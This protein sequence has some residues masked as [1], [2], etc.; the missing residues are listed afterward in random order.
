MK[1]PV[2]S[3]L[4]VAAFACVLTCIVTWPQVRHPAMVADHF[5]PY[6]SVW[7]LSHIA[8]A[9]TRWPIHLFDGNIFYPL[10]N[11]LA[12]SDATLLQGL[13]AAPFLWAHLSP[14]LVYNLLLLAGFVGSGVGMFVLARH[15][16]GDTGPSLIATTIFTILPYRVEHVMHLELQW[17]MFI[18]LSL[19]AVHRTMESGR[20]RYGLLAGLFVWLQFLSCVYYGVFLGLA[21]LVFVPLLLTFKGHAPP[22]A[23]VPPLLCGGALAVVLTLPY[24]WPYLEAARAVGARPVDEITR[25]SAQPIS[26]LRLTG[27]QSNLGM[28]LRLVGSAR[29]QAVPRA[30]RRGARR[31]RSPTPPAAHGAVVRSD[32]LRRRS[33][34]IRSERHALSD[35]AGA[36]VVPAGVPV[37]RPIRHLCRLLRSPFSPRWECRP[38]S[39]GCRSER[40]VAE[41]ASRSLSR[42]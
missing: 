10:R 19:W 2:P 1:K 21:L 22:K 40:E 18:P 9:L 8:H 37:T 24:A 4:G 28:D 26:Y 7:R 42:C 39:R 23:F 16:T 29:A 35:P 11:T 17:A 3:L 25:Y 13:L 12:Y 32:D 15:V 27:A 38:C 34:V 33:T 6:F 20:W 41:Y 30:A 36:R 31:L 14:S 5:D